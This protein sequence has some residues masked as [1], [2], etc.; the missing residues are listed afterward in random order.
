L[1]ELFN[2]GSAARPGDSEM[3]ALDLAL[4]A[5]LELTGAADGLAA[6]VSPARRVTVRATTAL[7]PGESGP[8]RRVAQQALT[9]WGMTFECADLSLLA[10]SAEAGEGDIAL[11]AAAVDAADRAGFTW[12]ALPVALALARSALIDRDRRRAAQVAR[13]NATAQH[14]AA[15]LDLDEVLTNVVSDAVELLGGDTGDMI[16]LDEDRDVLRVAA[17]AA[18]PPEMVGFEMARD[19]GVSAAAMSARRT[20]QVSDY[21]R[22]GRRVKR[23]DRFNF[24]AVLCAPLIAREHPIGALNVHAAEPGRQFTGEDARLLAAFANHAAIAIDNA[25]RFQEEVRLRRGLAEANLELTRA[26]TIQQRLARQV[27]LD[28]G[29]HAVARE[30]ASV[31]GRPVVIQDQLLRVICGAAPDGGECW[32]RLVLSPD[33]LGV[34]VIAGFLPGPAVGTRAGAASALTLDEPARWVVPVQAGVHDVIA[35]LVLPSAGPIAPLDQALLETAATGVALELVKMRARVE[36]EHRLRGDLMQELLIGAH[37]S[38]EGIA[39]RAAYVGYDLAVPRD[40]ILLQVDPVDPR[41]HSDAE[42]DV[43]VLQRRLFDIIHAELT[44]HAPASMVAMHGELTIALLAQ[45]RAGQDAPK[46]LSPRL[47]VQRLKTRLAA[48]FPGISV[49][50]VIGE[51]CSDPGDYPTSYQRALRVLQ[52][53]RK[54]GSRDALVQTD[55]LG[56]S[57]LLISA[58]PP[59]ELRRFAEEFFRPLLDGPG[60]G[61]ELLATLRAY[62]ESGFNQREAARR[63][64]LHV[65]TIV[66]RLRRI[67]TLLGIDLRRPD[68]LLDVMVALRTAALADLL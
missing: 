34:P 67:E 54:L 44:S 9:R 4:Q 28:R 7:H 63:C 19:E 57:G 1:T 64:F 16:L 59:Q 58:A 68:D 40:V 61:K 33:L 27:V 30:L 48:H 39:A 60:H 18:C 65:N 22:Y 13:L 42:A 15:S 11:V 21:R 49:S 53:V 50:A 20:I 47:I 26:L 17:V 29:P 56:V 12:R 2:L 55:E 3:S 10:I 36:V 35:Y 32:Q 31:L 62:V 37:N 66:Q 23:L 43:M 24:R 14:V 52:A 6:L 46:E 45:R 25:R 51:R 8:L 41:E 5:I 38:A